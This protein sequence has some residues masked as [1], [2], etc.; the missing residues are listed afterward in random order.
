MHYLNLGLIEARMNQIVIDL[1][2]AARM[3]EDVD[4]GISTSLRILAHEMHDLVT[5]IRGLLAS[6][7]DSGWSESTGTT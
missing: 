3:S 4:I 6:E 2:D 5:H 7:V 1:H